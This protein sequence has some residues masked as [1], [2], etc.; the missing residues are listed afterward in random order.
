MKGSLP[1]SAEC[2]DHVGAGGVDPR[3]PEKDRSEPEVLELQIGQAA[4]V[5]ACRCVTARNLGAWLIGG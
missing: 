2:A 3:S 4:R 1:E 5:G